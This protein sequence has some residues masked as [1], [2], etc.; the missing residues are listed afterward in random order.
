MMISV[1]ASMAMH[2]TRPAAKIASALL[3]LIVLAA[4]GIAIWYR[5][6]YN[7]WPGQGASGRVHWCGRDYENFGGPN[8]A[9]SRSPP[10]SGCRSARPGNTRRLAGHDRNC[11]PPPSPRRSRLPSTHR[12]PAR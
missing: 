1:S 3:A 4:G 8:Q 10:S 2:G 12:C 6:T 11:S 9:G 5:Q 7:V